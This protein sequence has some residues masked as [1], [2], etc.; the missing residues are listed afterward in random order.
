[1]ET[2]QRAT[3]TKAPGSTAR[4]RLAQTDRAR[5]AYVKYFYKC[6]ARATTTL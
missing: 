1:V 5:E 4:K 6:D 3:T 2:R